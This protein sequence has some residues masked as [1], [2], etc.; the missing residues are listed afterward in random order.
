MNQF[1]SKLPK[2]HT[3]VGLLVLCLSAHVPPIFANGETVGSA[4]TRPDKLW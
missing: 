2:A 4:S 3:F 1:L